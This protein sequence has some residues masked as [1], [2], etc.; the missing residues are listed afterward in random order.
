[1]YFRKPSH[2]WKYEV[3]DRTLEPGFFD[4]YRT[5]IESKIFYRRYDPWG[6]PFYVEQENP[7]S[8]EQGEALY[9]TFDTTLGRGHAGYEWID[10]VPFESRSSLDIRPAAELV[11][12]V[13]A[14]AQYCVEQGVPYSVLDRTDCDSLTRWLYTDER[15]NRQLVTVAGGLFLGALAVAFVNS[16]GSEQQ[17]RS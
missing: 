4:H 10:A 6:Q 2:P 5:I 12:S 15:W 16:F 3:G 7:F 13:L 11:P 17:S 1:M 9:L 8:G 14:R